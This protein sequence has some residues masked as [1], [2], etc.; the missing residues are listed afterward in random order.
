MKHLEKDGSQLHVKQA[1]EQP[2]YA[3]VRKI[4][5]SSLG[6]QSRLTAKER[7]YKRLSEEERI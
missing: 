4:E 5:L 1:L 3:S 2:Q 6:N 7:E